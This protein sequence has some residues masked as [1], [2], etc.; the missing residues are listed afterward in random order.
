LL[1][2]DRWDP[3]QRKV[4]TNVHESDDVEHLAVVGAVVSE[5][6]SEDDATKVT[7]GTSD[8]GDDTVLC[9]S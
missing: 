1:L 9:S 6:D 7:A 8:T 4:D 2:V 5:D 3:G